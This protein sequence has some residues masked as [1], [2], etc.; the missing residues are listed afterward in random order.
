MPWTDRLAVAVLIGLW[1]LA[2]FALLQLGAGPLEIVLLSPLA[3]AVVAVLV[4]LVA[5]LVDSAV[6]APAHRDQIRAKGASELLLRPRGDRENAG[7]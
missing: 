1:M 4:W 5:R 2:A 7:A 6:L 3:A